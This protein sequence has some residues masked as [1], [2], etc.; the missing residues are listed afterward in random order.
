V[1]GR[2]CRG[3]S[4]S[5]ITRPKFKSLLLA[6]GS[7][8][9]YIG[10]AGAENHFCNHFCCAE[11]HLVL[12]MEEEYVCPLLSRARVS[13]IS[14]HTCS[15]ERAWARLKRRSGDGFQT[16]ASNAKKSR[17]MCTNISRNN[18]IESLLQKSHRFFSSEAQCGK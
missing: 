14:K 4:W 2:V 3:T 15:A 16:W 9:A 7:S 6:T 10:A 13:T 8:R 12:I 18:P 1:C 5:Q 11:N 17:A